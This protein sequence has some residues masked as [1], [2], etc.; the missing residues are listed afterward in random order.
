M[1]AGIDVTAT[2]VDLPEVDQE[3]AAA[4][5]AELGCLVPRP[6]LAEARGCM[7]PPRL[8]PWV[9]ELA[10]GLA[11]ALREM[12]RPHLGLT[13][14]RGLAGTAV[15]G[16]TTFAIDETA[17][18]EIGRFLDEWGGRWP[19]TPRTR[20]CRPGATREYVLI[21]DPIDGTRPAAAG[22]EAAC[23]SIAVARWSERP[24]MADVVYGVV[25]EIKEGGVFR[26]SGEAVSI[27]ATATGRPGPC[28]SR[29]T[30]IS[31]GCSGPSASGGARP[32]SWWPS[33]AT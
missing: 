22:F 21:V 10:D 8:D 12:V 28:G 20:A 23:V 25:Q 7:T 4:L 24:T 26:A 14:A 1:A 16:D 30:P 3:A 6:A 9:T 27:S 11:S 32:S 31:P 19:S 18:N 29:A 13:A 15:G 5:A 17:E 33:S 2:V